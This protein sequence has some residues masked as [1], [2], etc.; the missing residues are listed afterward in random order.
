MLA[1][2][3]GS[4][5][6][7]P[8]LLA[9]VEDHAWTVAVTDFVAGEHGLQVYQRAPAELEALFRA[10]G[11]LLAAVHR[12][13]PPLGHQPRIRTAKSAKG[14]NVRRTKQLRALRGKYFAR[15]LI[16]DSDLAARSRRVL[17]TLPA[18]DLDAELR[19]ALAA[20]LAHPA[21]RPPAARLV[22]GDA[23][24]HNLLW[25]DG[26]AA[27]LD[28]EWAGVGNPLLDLAWV[29]W[30][31]RWRQLPGDLWPAFLAAYT[32]SEPPDLDITPDALRAL[33]LGQIAGILARVAPQPAARQEWLRRA[34]WTLSLDWPSA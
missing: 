12:T 18:L 10:L 4:G 26:I 13:P 7:V 17:E 11:Q 15:V 3:R 23:G 6:P 25:D 19:D 32:S 33:A 1:L 24:L 27:L 20:A 8:P 29:G 5:L 28:W 22:H 34:R 30:T 9:L 31:M 21:W 16:T 14:L 2:L